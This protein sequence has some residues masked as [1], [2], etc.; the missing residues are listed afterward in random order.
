MK[1]TWVRPNVSIV[2]FAAVALIGT[3][4]QLVQPVT[5][6][7]AQVHAVELAAQR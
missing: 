7:L 3:G 2:V 6:P 5:V 1:I 4:F